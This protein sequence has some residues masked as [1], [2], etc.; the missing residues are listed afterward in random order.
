M[1]ELLLEIGTEELPPL[2]VEPALRQLSDLTIAALEYA[3]LDAGRVQTTGTLRR[4]VLIV[5]GLGVRQQDHVTLVRGPAARVAYD[6]AGQPTPA[7]AGFARAQGVP[8]SA[9]QTRE[10]EGGKYVVAEIREPG[11]RAAEVVTQLLPGVIAGLTFPKT[12][13]WDSQGFRFGR[14]IRRIVALLDGRLLPIEIA[15]VR[16]GRKTVGHRFLAPRVMALTKAGVY[17]GAMRRANVILT[18]EDRRRRIVDLATAAARKAGGRPVLDPALLEE[19][20]WSTEYPTP[21]LGKIDLDFTVAVPRPVLIVALQ[22]HQKSFAV[23]GPDGALLPAFV[24]IRDGGADHLA[25]IRTGHEWVVRARLTDARFFLEEDRR[26]GFAHWD[27]VLANIHVPPQL[28]VMYIYVSRVKETAQ[29]LANAVGATTSE[30]D[31]VSL[32]AELCKSDLASAMVRE[33]PELQGAMGAIYARETGLPEAVARAIEEHYMPRGAGNS[34]AP[35]RPGAILAIADRAVLLA[36]ALVPGREVSGSQDPYGLRRAASGIIA[37]LIYHSFHFS[38]RTMF[39]AVVQ[40]R[41]FPVE[42]EAEVVSVCVEFTLQRLRTSLIDQGITYDTVDAVMATGGDDVVDL[43]NRARAL[44][45]VRIRPVMARLA[46]GFARASR[47]LSQGTPAPAVDESA[48]AEPAEMDLFRAWRAAREVVERA[49]SARRYEEALD[50]LAGLADPIDRF[51]NDVLV[52]AQDQ[53]IRANRL[54]L[55]RGVS[56]TFLRVA[57]FGKLTG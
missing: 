32:A 15:G 11:R 19:L 26:T 24:A 52:M 23:E 41:R 14:P 36:G 39:E 51:F 20:V 43:A 21:L 4:L 35:S 9:L 6:A 45:A 25:S 28:D 56:D 42:W 54:A 55:L 37:T 27:N 13:R 18:P 7:A 2:A 5:E 34:P 47:I 29:W 40:I 44:Q 16:A 57:D 17:P 49:S 46:T 22:H 12:M 8:V 53:R 30:Y 48:L 3:R 38:L 10:M 31:S 1:S 33:F 50:A